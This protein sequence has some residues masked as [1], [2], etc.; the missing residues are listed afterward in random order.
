MK[1]QRR[2]E[3]RERNQARSKPDTVNQPV[4]TARIFVHY[5]NSTHYCNTETFFLYSPS[6]RPTSHLSCG[7]LEAREWGGGGEGH[8]RSLLG[9][10]AAIGCRSKA[11]PPTRLNC[12]YKQ[13]TFMPK[14]TRFW[15]DQTGGILASWVACGPW[16]VCCA[17][18]G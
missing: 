9:A 5:Y 12:Q 4:R 15:Q 13:A 14:L 16:A 1:T 2:L 10:S 6:S 17:R 11:P 8:D 7:Q 3:D 18:Q